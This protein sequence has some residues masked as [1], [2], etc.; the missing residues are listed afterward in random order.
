MKIHE[1]KTIPQFFSDVWDGFK[2]FEVRENDRNFKVGDLLLL[3]EYDIERHE[4]HRY[5]GREMLCEINYIYDEAKFLK[6]GYVILGI[7]TLKY[8]GL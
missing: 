7:K 8:E 1:L 5:M 4:K 2:S 6:E 3:R